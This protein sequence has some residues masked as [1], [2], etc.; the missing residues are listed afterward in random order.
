MSFEVVYLWV[1]TGADETLVSDA[2]FGL[3]SLAHGVAQ[4]VEVVQDRVTIC[5][6]QV[7]ITLHFFIRLKI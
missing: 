4:V 6:R 2:A 7:G 3:V 5:I 1:V